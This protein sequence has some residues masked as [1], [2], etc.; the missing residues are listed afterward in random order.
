MAMMLTYAR[1]ALVIPFAACFFIDA[2]WTMT[3][4]LAIFIAAAI[5]DFLDGRVARARGEVSA[6]GAALDPLAD[7]LLLAAALLLLVRNGVIRDA[8]VIAALIMLLRE[9]AVT[10]LRE[11]VTLAG[12][13]LPVTLLAK[14]KT[15]A[16]LA[17]IAALLAAAPG[18]LLGA[19]ARAP[20]AGLLWI[21]AVLTLWTGATYG[22]SAIR[23]LRLRR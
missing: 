7:K 23:F 14:W 13:S 21:A 3:A 15:A 16:Q 17:A 12:G 4:A 2:P 5:T 18:G 9:I 1:F 11:A 20:A 6:L 19:G 22:W 8:G 10:G